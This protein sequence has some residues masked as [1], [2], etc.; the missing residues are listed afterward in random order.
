MIYTIHHVHPSLNARQ[1][2]TLRVDGLG[3]VLA[4]GASPAEARAIVDS[5]YEA[6]VGS[7]AVC[8]SHG[9]ISFRSPWPR[10]RRRVAR[11]PDGYEA[12]PHALALLR[13]KLERDLREAA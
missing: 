12:I 1:R 11:I 10:P 5:L 6:G 8:D 2:Q 7:A 13:L 9:R 4:R 3:I